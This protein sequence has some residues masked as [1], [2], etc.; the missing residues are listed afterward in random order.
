MDQNETPVLDA[1]AEHQK[2]DRYGFTPPAHRQGRG[3]DPRVL[4]V[5]GEQSFKSDVVASSGLDDRKSSNGYLSKAEELMAEAVGADK[6]FFST[7]GSSLSIKAAILAVTRGEGELLIG[8]DAHKSV[9]SGLVLSGLQPRWIK[10]KWDNELKLAHPPAPE[11]V[12]EM[13]Q[14]YP[15]ASAALIVSPTPYGT[16]ADLEAIVE[17]CHKRGKPLIV[18]EAWGAQL[19]FHPDTPTW[20]MSAGADICVVS[21][22]K[23]G[24]GF[25]QGSIFH[26]QGNL[27]DPVRLNQCADVLST[28]SANVM[29]YAAMDGWRRQMVQDGKAMID[30]ALEL[31]KGLRRDI[32]ALPGLHVLEDELVH[33]EAS[34]DLDILHIMIDVSELGISGFQATD[35]LR[36]NCRIDMGTT[37]HRRT[38][39][40]ISISD[41]EETAQRLLGGLRALIEAAPD[42]PRPPAVVIPDE[43]DLYLKTVMLPRDA[44]F[45]PVEVIPCEEA[46]G[47]IAAEMA[48]PYPPGIP[49]LLPGERI[50]KAAI[51]YLRSGVEAGMVLPDPADPT[52]K[53]I[54][55]VREEPHRSQ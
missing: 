36:E 37:D 54:R 39:A 7:C 30:K 6:A 51:D 48:T 29:L 2:L 11:T 55:V 53:T 32:Q 44:F 13:W 15:D 28:T 19:P 22:H 8:R 47:R 49:I 16:C 46:P 25:E 12:E 10:P 41:D 31:A 27:V 50:N 24:L 34:H 5:L 45:G 14:R 4:E 9:V 18:D 52:L 42:L 21:V 43:E 3:V 1:L 23:M 17:I 35:W 26:L 40:V 20:A 38:E 33:A